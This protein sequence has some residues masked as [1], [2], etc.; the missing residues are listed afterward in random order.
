M[1]SRCTAIMKLADD[2]YEHYKCYGR[3]INDSVKKCLELQ[4]E[5]VEHDVLLSEE[6]KVIM[7]LYIT[8][9]ITNI[10]LD[11]YLQHD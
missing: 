2:T 7:R 1:K 4:R 9:Y 6:E 10:Y 3:A 11:K 8:T 5:F